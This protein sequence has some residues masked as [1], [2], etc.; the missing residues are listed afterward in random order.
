MKDQNLILNK[1]SIL[2]PNEKIN[3]DLPGYAWDLLP[4]KNKT[5]DLYRA[6]YWHSFF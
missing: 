4:K 5:L 1:P 2:V 3:T 6:H